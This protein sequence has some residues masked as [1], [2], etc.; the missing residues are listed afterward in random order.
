MKLFYYMLVITLA[1]PIFANAEWTEGKITVI[2]E[3][4]QEKYPQWT[5]KNTIDMLEKASHAGQYLSPIRTDKGMI[6]IMVM[7]DTVLLDGKDITGNLG[8]KTTYGS[9]SPILD[10]VKADNVVIGQN[11]T[12]SVQTLNQSQTQNGTAGNQPMNQVGTNI[13]VVNG[14]SIAAKS[15]NG[16]TDDTNGKSKKK[17]AKNPTFNIKDS[18]VNVGSPV[19]DSQINVGS[20]I[21]DSQVDIGSFNFN[22]KLVIVLSI[23]FSLSVAFSIYLLLKLRR[24]KT[25]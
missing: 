20:T 13:T 1:F 16:D 19:K 18:Q 14:N 15:I 2:T 10:N 21:K 5:T 22:I 3:R 7:G 11:N 24:K 4:I 25:P 8:S 9:N 17:D 12:V 23:V 6:R